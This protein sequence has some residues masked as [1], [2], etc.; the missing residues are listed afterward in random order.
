MSNWFFVI[1]FLVIIAFIYVTVYYHESAHVQINKYFGADSWAEYSL[2]GGLTHSTG[3]ESEEKK[4]LAYI[5]HSFNE[6]VSYNL[7]PLFIMLGIMNVF[8]FLYLGE[9]MGDKK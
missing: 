2:T 5:G 6:V 1:C 7:T 3:F 4:D 8:G 9:K